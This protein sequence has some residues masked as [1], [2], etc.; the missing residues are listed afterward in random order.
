M[1]IR[2]GAVFLLLGAADFGL[3][4]KQYMKEMMMS[5]E[6]KEKEYKEQ[7]G[8]PHV[9]GHRKALHQELLNESAM[10]EV[11]KATAVVVNPTH[12]AIALKYDE[13]TMNAPGVVAK[14]REELAQKILAL[15]KEHRVPVLRNVALARRLIDVEV[16]KDIPEE[17]YEAV[18]EVLNFVYQ[19]Q[20]EAAEG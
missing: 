2:T 16:G 13:K 4:K 5:K 7:E 19:M 1:L 6:E 15:A 9:K 12:L 10:H 20:Q 3:Q 17:L 11:P 8:D 14:G 18:A